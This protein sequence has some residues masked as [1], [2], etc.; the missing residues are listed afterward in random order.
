MN[1]LAQLYKTLTAQGIK[2]LDPNGKPHLKI[3]TPFSATI[4]VTYLRP[5]VYE[6]GA[7]E[8]GF[9]EVEGEILWLFGKRK[10]RG[11]KM[12]VQASLF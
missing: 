9:E 1:Q 5:N 6:L 10:T 4:T 3:V 11:Y 8:M 2:I 7:T 12:L